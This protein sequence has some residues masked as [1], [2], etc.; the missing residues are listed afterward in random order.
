MRTLDVGPALTVV[1]RFGFQQ[2]V[3][4]LQSES[5]RW[6]RIAAF[7]VSRANIMLFPDSAKRIQL[8]M[9]AKPM[10]GTDHSCYQRLLSTLVGNQLCTS[11]LLR[12]HLVVSIR[13]RLE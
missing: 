8:L 9:M 5:T 10:T 2:V 6:A 3:Q 4:H 1:T 11:S 7:D 13:S 12:E